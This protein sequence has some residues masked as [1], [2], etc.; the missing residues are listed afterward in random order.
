MTNGQK[1][2]IGPFPPKNRGDKVRVVN[3]PKNGQILKTDFFPPGIGGKRSVTHIYIY[4]YIYIYSSIYVFFRSNAISYQ[5]GNKKLFFVLFTFR[6]N[7]IRKNLLF[8][9]KSDT[10]YCFSYQNDD[11]C[12]CIILLNSTIQLRFDVF[13]INSTLVVHRL[14][15]YSMSIFL[16]IILDF[17]SLNIIFTIDLFYNSIYFCTMQNNIKIWPIYTNGLYLWLGTS[18]P[19]W[20]SPWGVLGN[21]SARNRGQAARV[22]GGGCPPSRTTVYCC[23]FWI[24]PNRVGR[25]FIIKLIFTPKD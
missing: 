5:Y 4:I 20:G 10:K 21:P 16:I 6:S 8:R 12:S 18:W 14:D 19:P 15:T 13:Y 7:M 3:F 17:N 9:T 2:E 24:K 1:N 25:V 11:T 23:N 22:L